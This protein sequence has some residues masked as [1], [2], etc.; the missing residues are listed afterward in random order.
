MSSTKRSP[1][2]LAADRLQVRLAEDGRKALE[3]LD[4]KIY[5]LVFMDVMMPELDG[6]EATKIIRAA[7]RIPP[8]TPTT[9]DASSS[10]P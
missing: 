8:T 1:P 6:M 9:A 2:H 3:A 7:R 5:D 4:T 10:W